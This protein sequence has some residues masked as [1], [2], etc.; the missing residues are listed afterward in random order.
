MQPQVLQGCLTRQRVEPLVVVPLLSLHA[1]L[2]LSWSLFSCSSRQVLQRCL[3][4]QRVEPLVVAPLLS[5]HACL[6]VLACLSLCPCMP[7]SFCPCMPVEPLFMQLTSGAA[8]LFD[9]AKG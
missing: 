7:V 8:A 3:T 9:P 6:L 5:L 4:R 2:F 1:C